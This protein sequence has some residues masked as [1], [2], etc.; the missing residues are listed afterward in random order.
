MSFVAIVKVLFLL[1]SGHFFLFF[2]EFVI[3]QLRYQMSCAIIA[4]VDFIFLPMRSSAGEY[5]L[6][7]G[8]D[9]YATSAFVGFCSFFKIFFTVFTAFFHFAVRLWTPRAACGVLESPLLYKLCEFC[10]DKV[11]LSLRGKKL[12]FTP[13]TYQTK[14]HSP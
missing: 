8:V 10:T 14:A 4:I 5:P 9:L 3:W 11:F 12:I 1:R 6:A 7:N 2:E 13:I